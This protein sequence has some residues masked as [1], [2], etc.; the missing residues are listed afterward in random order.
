MGSDDPSGKAPDA[1][2]RGR[3]LLLSV[4]EGSTVQSP[5]TSASLEVVAAADATESGAAANATAMA[6]DGSAVATANAT[7]MASDGSAVAA[8]N[9]TA[10]ASDG[11][12]VVAANAAA[13]N[14]I[15][16]ANDPITPCHIRCELCSFMTK[17]TFHRV[18]F[19]RAAFALLYSFPI[20]KVTL[21]QVRLDRAM[22]IPLPLRPRH[23]R[24]T[25]KCWLLVS[26]LPFKRFSEISNP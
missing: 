11:I 5:S 1:K 12:T 18:R 14:T 26:E 24:K 10:L 20:T 15:A 16:S 19:G 3:H 21:D 25:M 13:G 7:A 6:S 8:A 23:V 4:R 17:V 2:F 9:A 22:V